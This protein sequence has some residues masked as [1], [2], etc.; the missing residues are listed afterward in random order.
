MHK[1][2]QGF[3]QREPNTKSAT[4]L[5]PKSSYAKIQS[6]FFGGRFKFEIRCS[7]VQG[8]G[9]YISQDN[10]SLTIMKSVA[11]SATYNFRK[12][13]RSMQ[14]LLLAP[15]F[16][17]MFVL[18]SAVDSAYLKESYVA[19]TVIAKTK[20]ESTHKGNWKPHFILALRHP[21]GTLQD[22]RTSYAVYATT[23]VGSTWGVM[24]SDFDRGHPMPMGDRVRFAVLAL[25]ALG[26][27]LSLAWSLAHK[28]YPDE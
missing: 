9:S 22:V 7:G 6:A 14:Y 28:L 20:S 4:L 18:A 25:S 24:Y 16:A 3:L 26:V 12:L 15:L 17:L 10:Y 21:D 2:Q 8:G 11:I 23:P 27:L 1:S 19:A 13:S 5:A